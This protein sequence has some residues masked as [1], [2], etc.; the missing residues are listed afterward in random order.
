M[1]VTHDQRL[2]ENCDCT[3]WVVEKEGVTQWVK[4]FDDYKNSLLTEMEEQADK[5]AQ[6]RRKKLDAIA[7][8]RAE[9]LRKLTEALSK[10]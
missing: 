10:K 5:D 3:L 9:K 8:E 2:I 1:V 6:E 4:G 7:M